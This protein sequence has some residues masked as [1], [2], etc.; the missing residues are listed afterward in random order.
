MEPEVRASTLMAQLA[1][2]AGLESLKCV[3]CFRWRGF[4]LQHR[5]L[6]KWLVP[7]PGVL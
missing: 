6:A 5:V 2:E 4:S 3:L 7:P 1:V